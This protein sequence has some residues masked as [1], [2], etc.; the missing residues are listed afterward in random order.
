M[1]LHETLEELFPE[2]RWDK[3]KSKIDL[4]LITPV[5]TKISDWWWCKNGN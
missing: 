3:L 5:K 2:N 4:N 1:S